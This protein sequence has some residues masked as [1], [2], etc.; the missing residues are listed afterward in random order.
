MQPKGIVFVK[1]AWGLTGLMGLLAAGLALG[2][3]VVYPWPEPLETSAQANQKLFGE[4]DVKQVKTIAIASFS[5]DDRRFESIQLKKTRESWFITTAGDYPAGNVSRIA[6]LF[7]TLSE[8]TVLEIKSSDESTHPLYGVIDSELVR[9]LENQTGIGTKVSLA[10]TNNRPLAQLIVGEAV[11]DNPNQRFVRV[12]GQP[13]VYVIELPGSLLSTEVSDWVDHN[14]LDLK[15]SDTG[16]GLEVAKLQVDYYVIEGD[17][18]AEE[19]SKKYNYRALLDLKNKVAT[20][21]LFKPTDEGNLGDPVTTRSVKT[22]GLN[23]LATNLSQ[24]PFSAVVKKP[25]VA[26]NAFLAAIDQNSDLSGLDDFGFRKSSDSPSR[27]ESKNG[28]LTVSTSGGVDWILSFGSVAKSIDV[29]Q[30]Q[31]NYYLLITASPNDSAFPQPPEPTDAENSD[32]KRDYER[33]LKRRADSLAAINERVKQ[34]NERHAPWL[35]LI[36]ED[37]LLALRPDEVN[38]IQ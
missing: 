9:D 10:D 22:P 20:L 25:E 38:L 7:T 13:N 4:L 11:G 34:Y 12:V 8:G 28:Q 18:V 19:N 1:N 30:S 36:S 3:A 32:Q 27:I 16:T 2:A 26:A 29:A 21:S 15:L 31:I 14:L 37:A 23:A 24:I 33:A 17:S 35:Y 5:R 6:A